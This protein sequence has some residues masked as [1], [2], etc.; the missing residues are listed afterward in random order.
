M[1]KF[2]SVFSALL[3]AAI[4][5]SLSVSTAFADTYF[6]T[7]EFRFKKV[8]GN[9]VVC[10]Y[11]GKDAE[12]MVIPEKLLEC[13]VTG[14]NLDA[15]YNRDEIT[16]VTLPETLKFIDP[17]A[18]SDMDGLKSITIPDGCTSLGASTFRDCKSLE[19][20]TLSNNLTEI[21]PF[22]FYNCKSLKNVYIPNGVTYIG[23][24]AFADCSSMT[25][26]TIPKSVTSMDLTAFDNCR[27]L[28]IIGYKGSF[29]EEY[30]NGCFIPFKAID[31]YQIGDVNLDKRLSVNDATAIQ[32]HLAGIRSLSDEGYALADVNGDGRVSILDATKIQRILCGLE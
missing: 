1:K 7:E 29:A 4:I 26:V 20:V 5:L 24:R 30:A 17:Y 31:E 2:T 8:N 15:F 19:S 13:T 27:N 9:A 10:D 32:K 3:S 28:T 6:S 25:S 23:K 16:S 14:V 12:N 21:K 22:A 11:F 18:F